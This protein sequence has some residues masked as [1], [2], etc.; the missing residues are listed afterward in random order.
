MSSFK[1]EFQKKGIVLIMKYYKIFITL[2]IIIVSLGI[3]I[4]CGQDKKMTKDG[5]L[6][7]EYWEKWTGFEGDAMKVI[8]ED[9]NA[10]QDKIFVRYVMTEQIN[11]KMQ[12]AVAGGNPPDV[13]G[14][15][16]A[17]INSFA[18]MN[19]L[20]PIDDLI[21]ENGINKEDY[22][23]MCMDVCTRRGITWGLPTTPA[24]IALHWNKRLFK[25]AGLNPNRPPATLD[26]LDE[27]IEK[28]TYYKL[29]NGKR[30]SYR[31]LIAMPD[32]KRQ[33]ETA[34]LDQIGF[35][36]FEPGWWNWAWFYWFGGSYWN[37]KD[38]Y[39][40]INEENL[41]TFE[42]I[43][44]FPKKY[45]LKQVRT[46]SSGF[47]GQFA[48]SQ[49]PFLCSKVAMEMQGVW[50]YNFIRMY[51]PGMDWGAGAFPADKPELKNTSFGECDVLVIPKGAKHP[52]EGFE[53]IKY[54]NTP[55]VMEKLCIGQRKFS[56]FKKV[57]DDFYLKNPHPYIKL[58]ETLAKSPNIHTVPPIPNWSEF[59]RE[60]GA[61][62]D[63]LRNLGKSPDDAL[64]TLQ[65]RVQK[66]LDRK[67]EALHRRGKI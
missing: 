8:V 47:G 28:L 38:K 56:S 66:G 18:D 12:A 63:N 43:T 49:N 36:P 67:L 23:D 39:T 2:L 11:Q 52:E 32:Y 3:L 51:A 21:K 31:E 16:G 26:E 7:I 19:V 53:F 44:S 1:S 64:Q 55:A 58:F 57:S 60:F 61:I 48:S 15:W 62:H 9:F 40:L 14:L 33:M 41:K 35:L 5:R 59:D 17:N 45:G 4:S 27:Y 24:S 25:E 34:E 22:L 6:I 29:S 13:V 20:T 65:D 37:G 42:W 50:M 54:V 10:S 46:F 30:V